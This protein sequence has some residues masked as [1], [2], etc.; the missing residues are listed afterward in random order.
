MLSYTDE[1][2]SI[3]RVAVLGAGVMGAQ[4]A[5]HLANASIGV[6]LYDLPGDGANRNAN[7]ERA[8]AGLAKLH[9]APLALPELARLIA[10]ANYDD[11]LARLADCDLVIEAVS[12]R[13]E[14]KRLLYSRIVSHLKPNAILASNTSGLGIARLAADLPD[15]LRP[16]FCGV[17]FFNPPRYMHL[18]ELI[19]HPGTAAAVLDRLEGFCT[20]VLGKGVVR[21]KDRP[22]FVANRIGVFA[23]L[24]V[25]HHA[26]RLGLPLD[27]VDRLTG[28][29]IGRP[30]SATFRTADV[31]GLDTFAHIVAE[32]HATLPDD[33]WRSVYQMPDWAKALIDAGN[34][35]QKSGAGIYRKNGKD[36]QVFDPVS[37]DY[38]RVRSAMTDATRELLNERDP[39]AKFE[40][41]LALDHPHGE[42]L[43]A[44]LA[45]LL[46][47]SAVWLGDIAA[48]ARDLD[49]AM[50]WGYGWRLGPFEIWQAIGFQR[51][52]QWLSVEI[53]EGRT[54]ASVALPDWARDPART[55]V[56][57]PA[58]SYSAA[59]GL[60]E[61]PSAHPVY[62]RQAVREGVLGAAQ[63]GGT[64]VFEMPDARLWHAGDDIAVLS[65]RT[66]MHTVTPGV[67]EAGLRAIEE[68]TRGFK[69]LILWQDSD[70]FSAGAN[71]KGAIE[72]TGR[73][74]LD[75]VRRLI[76]DF[77]QLTM[78]LKHSPV[79][80]V[81]ATRGLALGG[82]CELVLHCDR[83][84]AAFETYIGLVE[85]GVGLIP[86]AG[87]SKELARRASEQTPDGN[88]LPYLRRVFEQV[89]MAKVA[90]NAIEARRFGYLRATDPIVF[91]VHELLHVA[92]A[93]VNSLYEAGYVPPPLSSEI[94]VAGETGLGIFNAF[95]ANMQAGGFI[96]EHD[97]LIGSRLARVLCG[98]ELPEG[99]RVDD[100]WLLRLELETF[101]ELAATP[102]TQARIAHTLSTGKPL[103]N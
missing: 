81:A 17:H 91:N 99:A 102:K 37:G 40:R 67:I 11:D 65:F 51:V 18:V 1:R 35:G 88:V 103:R 73:G 85:T 80:T 24:S 74:D 29:G 43:R 22:N 13:I 58:G 59:T 25:I 97:Y 52:A 38:R 49:L 46:H 39:V 84:V 71:L 96:S 60:D 6:I 30:K 32:L 93:E 12:E 53:A 23:M 20:Q 8:I 68:T 41:L 92:R 62:R 33:P 63:D 14:I 98:G 21:A 27:L 76:E 57:F 95:L 78:A 9:P 101:L 2:R 75:Y 56:H 77:Q 100:A 36:L 16:R 79:P 82:G 86:A 55:G 54:L 64:S 94:V 50:R 70:P 45:D 31:V 69:G 15:A 48:N 61:P 28:P 87:G 34:I 4:I 83:T 72:A 90:G 7:V 10:P 47:Y 42:F 26:G 89:A 19:G 3:R 66:K 5:A 44:V